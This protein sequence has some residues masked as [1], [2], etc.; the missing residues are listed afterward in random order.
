MEVTP[1][2]RP[3]RGWPWFVAILLVIIV[4]ISLLGYQQGECVDYTTESGATSICTSGP[5]LGIAG[6][7]ILAI[8]SLAA[9]AYFTRRIVH[10]ARAQRE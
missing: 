4:N 1:R 9:I 2:F 10:L 6:T 7:W 3:P 8:V 5:A